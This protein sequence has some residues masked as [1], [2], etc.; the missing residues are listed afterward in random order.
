MVEGARLAPAALARLN[1][2][3]ASGRPLVVSPIS[4]WERGMLVARGRVASPVDP[5]TWFAR[6][7]SRKDV[8]LAPV[9]F[10][11]LS[12]ASFLPE[13][14]HRDPAD[15]I[16]IATARALDLTLITRDRPILAYADKGHVRALEC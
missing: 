3:A 2:E 15:R 5:K 6:I 12:D 9:T 16:L 7:V 4:A 11:I 14:I 10:E 1:A 13:P 8:S